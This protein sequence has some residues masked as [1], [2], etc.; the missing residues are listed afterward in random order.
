MSVKEIL[1]YKIYRNVSSLINF[2]VSYN[3]MIPALVFLA[4][5]H[6]IF[7]VVDSE[8]NPYVNNQGTI[9]GISGPDF[10]LLA[11]DTRLASDLSVPSRNIRRIFQVRVFSLLQ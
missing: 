6:S 8:F 11:A 5:L 4:F 10:C 7:V 3:V 1:E 2:I 9:V